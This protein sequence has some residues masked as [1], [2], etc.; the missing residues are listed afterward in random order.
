[1]HVLSPNLNESIYSYYYKFV[2][3]LSEM[4]LSAELA[5]TEGGF[6]PHAQKSIFV[7]FDSM[8]FHPSWNYRVHS[9]F[10]R[11]LL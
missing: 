4:F 3:L 7:S 11:H 1:M 2:C 9:L 8:S 5:L 10:W 6:E